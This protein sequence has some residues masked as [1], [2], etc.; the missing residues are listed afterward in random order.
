MRRELAERYAENWGLKWFILPNPVYGIWEYSLY[1]FN[2]DLDR[3]SR[4]QI[5]LHAIDPQAAE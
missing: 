2:F 3:T 1:D 4:I 5:K